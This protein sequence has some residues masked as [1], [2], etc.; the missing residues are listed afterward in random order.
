MHVDTHLETGILA[1]APAAARLAETIGFD[2]IWT[3]ETKHNPF[4]PLTLIAE[5]SS[6]LIC[7]TSIAIAFARSP[8]VLANIAW[9]LQ[10]YSQGRF[11]LGLG[12]QVKGHNERRFSVKWESPGPR[13]REVILALRAIWDCWQHGTPLRF[14]G[15]YY[16]FT[17]MTPFFNPGPIAH[18]HI[19]IHIAAI[20]P[21]MCRLVGELCDGIR[22]HS[23]NSRRYTEEVILPNIRAGAEKAGRSPDDI[24]ICGGGFIITGATSEEIEQEKEKVRQR[25]AFYASTRTYKPILDIHGWG[26]TC[27]ILHQM[28][29]RGEWEAMAGQITDEMLE[30]F[31]VWGTYDEIAEKVWE[32][33]GGVVDRVVLPFPR[34]PEAQEAMQDVVQAL[35]SRAERGTHRPA[36]DS[37]GS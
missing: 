13:M 25:I 36:S 35:K 5:H 7:G 26:E 24:A 6:R 3:P 1:E 15:R 33:Y 37:R 30:A 10:A 19:P 32:R 2:G 20:N 11:V 29:A 23:F 16:T 21:Y 18:P 4:L 12:T 28:A 22:L 31:A 9:D 14:Q 17:L 34:T 27:L 8:M